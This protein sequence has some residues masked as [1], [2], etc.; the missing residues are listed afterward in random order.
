MI[1]TRR[2]PTNHWTRAYGAAKNHLPCNI[3]NSIGQNVWQ[4][5]SYVRNCGLDSLLLCKVPKL[6]RILATRAMNEHVRVQLDRDHFSSILLPI[7]SLS[8]EKPQ[9]Y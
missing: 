8:A 2:E 6:Q 5:C 1:V 9:T 4:E 7:P 3:N